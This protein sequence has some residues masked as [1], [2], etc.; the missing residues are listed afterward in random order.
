MP[1]PKRLVTL[2][3]GTGSNLQAILEALSAGRINAHMV[4]VISNRAD[5]V[6]LDKARAAGVTTRTIEDDAELQPTLT[7]LRPDVIA[8][9]GFM[10]ILDAPLVRSFAGRI[11]NIHPS[12]LP[13]YKGLNTHQRVLDNGDREHGCSVHFVTEALDAGPVI[14][15]ARVPVLAGDNSDTLAARVLRQEHRIYPQVLAW[16]CDDRL[17]LHHDRCVFDREILDRPLPEPVG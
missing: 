12:L 11:L 2:I 16:Y 14:L 10:R 3:S 8:L 5:A 15:Q 1:T 13:G 6:G 9:A 7:E 17:R 4:C